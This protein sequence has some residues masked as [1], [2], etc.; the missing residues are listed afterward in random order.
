MDGLRAVAVLS[1]VLYHGWPKWFPGGFI[2]VDIFFVISG[3]LITSILLTQLE[4]G[5]FSVAD[6][7]ARRIRRIFPAL[8]LVLGATLCFGWLVLLQGEFRQIGKHVA[9]GGGFISN[10]VLWHESGY[11]DNDATTKPLLHLW[12][13]GVEEQFYFL[14]PLMLWLVFSRRL[15]FL[16][17]AALIFVLSMAGNLLAVE[18][19]P[20]AAFFSPLTRFWELMSGGVAAYLHLHRRP[21]SAGAGRLAS[22]VGAALLA[23]G[24]VLIKPQYVFPGWWALLPVA[25]VLLLILAGPAAP[26][27]RLILSRKPLVWTGLI[28]YP[29]YLWHWP[30]LSFGF[31]IYGDKPS[32][33][34]RAGLILAA[35]VLAFLTYRYLE[36]PLRHGRNKKR[37]I[38]GLG[39]GMAAAAVVGLAVA[40][41]LVHERINVHGAEVYLNA[42]NDSDFPGAKMVPYRHQGTLFQKVGSP[43]QGVTVFIGDSLM[44]QYGPYVEAAL[45]QQPARFNSVIFATSGGCP[46]IQKAVRLPLI[47]YS[48]CPQTVDAAYDLALRPEVNTVVIGASWGGYFSPA[49]HELEMADQG[50]RL[51]FP[52]A[53]AMDRAYQSLQHS[54]AQLRAQGKR[55]FIVLQ[56]PSGDA[57]DPRKM[58]TG[59]R[60]GSIQ[61]VAQIAPLSLQAFAAEN[62]ATRERLLGIAQATGAQ[63]INPL[64]FLCDGTLCPVLD[65]QGAPLYTDSIHMRPAYSRRAAG[66]LEPTLIPPAPAGAAQLAAGAH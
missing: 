39:G 58:Y 44:Q 54:V 9:A 38:A 10:L 7:Y 17:S 46:P 53:A 56:P 16:W 13:L 6:F 66:Y 30:L 48:H 49:Q 35:L 8:L 59:S 62:A 55:V 12:S 32:Y 3:F 1:V 15:S 33:L 26:V 63:V 64:D 34:I 5:S 47:R 37:I 31:I 65:Q 36:T 27:N 29:L 61:P 20:T 2:G 14:W 28:S 40:F 4:T 60:F 57:Y 11:F 50:A 23:V 51:A 19:N 45:A 25:G 52:A 43:A 18:S 41:G 22:W 42:L 24:F 21:W